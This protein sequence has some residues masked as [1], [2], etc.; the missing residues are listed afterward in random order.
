MSIVNWEDVF[1]GP[2]AVSLVSDDVGRLSVYLSHAD[3]TKVRTCLPKV[4]G[5]YLSSGR[6]TTAGI[7]E[8]K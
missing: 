4:T 6:F 3:G 8:C 7:E 1:V 2:W 5:T